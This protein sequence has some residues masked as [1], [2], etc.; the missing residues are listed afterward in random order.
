MDDLLTGFGSIS[1]LAILIL[2]IEELV[3]RLWNIDGL[4]ARIRTW[5]EGML[6]GVVGYFLGLGMF[7]ELMTPE[8]WPSWGQGTL[9]FSVVTGLFSAILANLGFDKWEQLKFILEKLK[10]RVPVDERKTP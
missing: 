9:G 6:L 4:G 5:F 2:N 1:T 8:W 3:D 7:A 10:V